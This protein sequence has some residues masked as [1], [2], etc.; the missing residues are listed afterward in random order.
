MGDRYRVDEKWYA[1]N[2]GDFGGYM[3]DATYWKYGTMV[4]Y[5]H[6]HIF[7][8]NYTILYQKII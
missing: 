1:Y 8:Y 7:I 2:F 5:I 4:G 6:Y 3:Y